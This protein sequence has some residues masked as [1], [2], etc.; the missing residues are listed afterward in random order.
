MKLNSIYLFIGIARK[1][2]KLTAGESLCENMLKAGKTGLLI[3][4]EDASD[5]TKKKFS[6]M[7]KYRNIPIEYFGEKKVLGEL[8]GKGDTA[9][10]CITDKGIST[11]LKEMIRDSS[12][13]PGVL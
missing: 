13:K 4:A 7:C 2:G 8:L 10:I 1:A 11:K 9:A 6:D 5:N 12:L 3:I